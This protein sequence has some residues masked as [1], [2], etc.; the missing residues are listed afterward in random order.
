MFFYL[1]AVMPFYEDGLPEDTLLNG[2][3]LVARRPCL[4]DRMLMTWNSVRFVPNV[5]AAPHGGISRVTIEVTS[6]VRE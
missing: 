3:E 1:L 5:H 4:A 2:F 6:E